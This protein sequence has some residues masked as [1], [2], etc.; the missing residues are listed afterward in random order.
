MEWNYTYDENARTQ[1]RIIDKLPRI[2]IW[3]QR[4]KADLA[5]PDT[6]ED[7]L[8]DDFQ[9]ALDRLATKLAHDPPPRLPR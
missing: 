7:V 1:V 3:Q 5:D 9:R 4:A 8:L 6:C 2:I